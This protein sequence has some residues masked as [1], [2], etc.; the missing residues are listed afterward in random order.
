MISGT[1]RRLRDRVAE[2]ADRTADGDRDDEHR[3]ELDA[4]Y[5]ARAPGLARYFRA[6]FRGAEDPNDLVHEV[7]ARLAGG[8][9]FAELRDPQ[10]YLSRILRN[11]L[12]DRKRRLDKRPSLVPLE[13]VEVAVPPDQ[14]HA[15]EVTQMHARYRAAVDAL[16]PRTRQVFLLH[17]VDEVRVKAIAEQLGISTRTVEWHLAQAILRIGE[18][19]DRE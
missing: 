2:P 11:F 19:L 5:R 10:A 1:F 6:R 7:F 3:R 9:S 12:I 4:I 16:P 8:K 14:S 17:R 13:D 15:I 18:A